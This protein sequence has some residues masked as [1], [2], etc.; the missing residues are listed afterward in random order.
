MKVNR[1]WVL[2]ALRGLAT[3][4]FGL[5]AFSW[6]ELSVRILVTIFGLYAIVEGMFSI[7]H[8]LTGL[9][10]GQQWSLALLEGLAS[11][12]AGIAVFVWPELTALV[13]LY[14][15]AVRALAIGILEMFTVVSHR[16]EVEQGWLLFLAGLISAAFGLFL[17]ARPGGG[18]LALLWLIALYA[19]V[20]GVVQVVL[21]F[22]LRHRDRQPGPFE[23]A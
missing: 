9:A 3:L 15:I 12:A 19:C 14:F 8:S 11:V 2:L 6:P 1:S 18:A 10:G 20:V 4:L 22:V 16:Q 23:A 7:V 21:A 5:V 13:L 17:I